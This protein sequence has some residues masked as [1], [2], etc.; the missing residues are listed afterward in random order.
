MR[1]EAPYVFDVNS[2]L[3]Y[4]CMLLAEVQAVFRSFPA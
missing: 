2:M 4:L 1:P 3:L